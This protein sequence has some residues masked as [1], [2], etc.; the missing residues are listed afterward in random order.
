MYRLS[1][2]GV[3]T[4]L[5]VACLPLVSAPEAHSAMLRPATSAVFAHNNL[6]AWCLQSDTA[7]VADCSFN[8]RSQC[9]ATA[10]GGLGECVSIMP[11]MRER[12][13]P[14]LRK[15]ARGGPQRKREEV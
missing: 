3:V 8:N 7:G 15:R 14:L 6:D 4:A 10:A 1:F 9:E 11:G 12:D 13:W 2:R 5:F